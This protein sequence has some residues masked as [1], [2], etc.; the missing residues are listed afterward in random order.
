MQDRR[1]F[2]ARAGG[3]ALATAMPPAL[4]AP[5]RVTLA[6]PGPGNLLTLPLPLAAHIGADRAEGLAFDIQYVGGGPQALRNMLERNSDFACAG[7][8]AL[9]LQKYNGKPVR[10]IVA[11]TRVPAYTLLVRSS[12]RGQIRKIADLPGRVVGV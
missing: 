8:S 2:L 3:L 10:C 12:L 11:M 5:L 7:L 9:S 6:V 1:R 4:A